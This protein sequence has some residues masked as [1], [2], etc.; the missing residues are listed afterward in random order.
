LDANNDNHSGLAE[1]SRK[2][3]E[4]APKGEEDELREVGEE[5]DRQVA[6]LFGLSEEEVGV[7][8]EALR[9]VYGEV[10]VVE[11]EEEAGKERT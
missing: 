7:V 6:R 4:F 5:I 11:A 8:K 10:E 9:V 2:V 3:H 1:L